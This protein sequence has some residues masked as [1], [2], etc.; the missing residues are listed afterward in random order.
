MGNPDSLH[1]LLGLYKSSTQ[2]QR[3]ENGK[4]LLHFAVDGMC[5]LRHS[6]QRHVKCVNIVLEWQGSVDAVESKMGRTCLQ[7]YIANPRWH[8]KTFE[9]SADHLG[10]VEQLCAAGANVTAEDREGSS[11]L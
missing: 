4:S 8:S 10:V 2:S 5:N 6:V 11:A 1:A 7:A 3:N 9:D